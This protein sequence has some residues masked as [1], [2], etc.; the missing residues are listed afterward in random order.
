MIK[1][2]SVMVSH[3]LAKRMNSIGVAQALGRWPQGGVL[4]VFGG[5]AKTEAEVF[6]Q[7]GG[8]PHLGNDPDVLE[9]RDTVFQRTVET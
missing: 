3:L 1:V 8:Q 7:S 9:G 2:A 5:E 4:I 6:P